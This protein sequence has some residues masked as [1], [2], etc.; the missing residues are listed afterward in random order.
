MILASAALI[1]GPLAS[2]WLEMVRVTQIIPSTLAAS[3]GA[4]LIWLGLTLIFGRFYC[5]T[6]CPIGTFTELLNRA[7]Q[8]I[9]SL[10]KSFSFRPA[11]K[12][13]K[14]ILIIYILTL[15]VG[16][17]VVGYV[18]EPWNIMRNLASVANPQ[19]VDTTW[20]AL[21]LNAGWGAICGL[22]AIIPVTI[23]AIIDGR[24][25][26]TTICPIGT[27]LGIAS[28]FSFYHIE[29]NPDLCSACGR[30]EDN[31]TARCIKVVSRY[32]DN[33]RCIRCLDCITNCPD[34]AIKLQINHNRPVTPLMTR[35]KT[36]S[37]KA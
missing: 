26:C 31:C 5:S 30:C 36:P 4:V 12:Y 18:I 9:P 10:K 17:V 6:V 32:V 13:S 3:A 15:V 27:A 1:L 8:S 25:F 23:L 16:I 7:S 22:I 20:L 33:S 11:S 19:A 34:Q 37:H 14:H 24:R 29:I 2:R 28:N 35:V 21:G